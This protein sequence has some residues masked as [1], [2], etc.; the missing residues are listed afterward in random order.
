MPVQKSAGLAQCLPDEWSVEWYMSDF[1][2]QDKMFFCDVP[3]DGAFELSIQS[4]LK[5]YVVSY[6]PLCN[7]S[8]HLQTLMQ[9]NPCNVL[10]IDQK[11]LSL[12][13]HTL[14][15]QSEKILALE[16]SEN[17]KT[18]EAVVRVLNFLQYNAVT[19]H[20]KLIVIGGGII[21]EIGGFAAAMYKRGIEWIYFPTTL[22]SMCDSCVGGKTSLNFAN[23]K[24]QLGLFSVPSAV[25]I[26]PEFLKTLCLDDIQS[27]LAEVLKH[28]ILAG[29]DFLSAYE[30]NVIHGKIADEENYQKLIMLSLSVKKAV[31]EADEFESCE[32]R[33]LNYGHTFGHAIEALS[34]YKI[35]H[36]KAVAMGMMMANALSCEKNLLSV[37]DKNYLKVLCLDLLTHA[38]ISFFNTLSKH[39]IVEF[40][41]QDKKTLGQKTTF[42]LI[43]KVGD[44][45]FVSECADT[46]LPQFQKLLI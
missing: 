20:E 42:V 22:L 29:Q 9:D 10:L 30:K 46:L 7:L 28:C 6:S 23:A 17:N 34:T 3:R 1:V 45:R 33:V 4:R 32:R 16:A 2:I 27:G 12:Y 44:T 15:F 39:N 31:V 37:E 24:N 8:A 13:S 26:Y 36:G 21:Q 5:S 41:K 25:Y 11:L 14:N 40:I 38:E 19:K 43:S 18:L 35:S